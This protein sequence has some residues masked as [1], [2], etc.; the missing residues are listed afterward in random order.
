MK[1][2]AIPILLAASSL[3]AQDK[4]DSVEEI[5]IGGDK[6]W[7]ETKVELGPGDRVKI[8]ATGKM[9]YSIQNKIMRS[10]III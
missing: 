10:M 1:S 2:L 9:K 3:W 8:T 4:P 6:Q 5:E 7:V